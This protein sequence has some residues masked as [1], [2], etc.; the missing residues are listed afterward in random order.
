[1][2]EG[3]DLMSDLQRLTVPT[4]VVTGEEE[5]DYV[6]P[7]ALTREYLRLWPQARSGVISKTGH[8]G[9][10]TRPDELSRVLD[11]FLADVP[12]VVRERRLIG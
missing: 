11:A 4:L 12:G 3:L 5:L 8:L 10:I 9:V 7:P 2:L 6:V 1:M